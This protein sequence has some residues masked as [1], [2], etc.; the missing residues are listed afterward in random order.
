MLVV[1]FDNEPKAAEGMNALRELDRNGDITLYANAVVSK[2]AIGNW[3]I[4]QA[5][6]EGS[7]GTATGLLTGSFIGLLGG[8][9]GLAIGAGVGMVAGLA[10]D[11][12]RDGIN[13]IFVEETS[14]ALAKG[15]T[16]I[17]A[18]ID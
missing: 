12:R 15:K 9:I 1:V 11:V 17:I 13:S 16:A 6:D 3:R 14:N 2:D 18:E 10:F 7:I 5:A 8:P 4:A